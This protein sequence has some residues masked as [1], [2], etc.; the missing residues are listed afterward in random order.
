MGVQIPPQCGG[1]RLQIVRQIV[2]GHR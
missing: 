1:T 2:P